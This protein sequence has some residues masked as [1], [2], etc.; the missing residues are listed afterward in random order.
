MPPLKAA[1]EAAQAEVEELK[2]VHSTVDRE[3]SAINSKI[4]RLEEKRTTWEARKTQLETQIRGENEKLEQEKTDLAGMLSQAKTVMERPELEH[5]AKYYERQ[6]T[7]LERA[8]AQEQTGRRD[9][10]VVAKELAAAQGHYA[11]TKETL[12]TLHTLSQQLQK[13][14]R[15]RVRMWYTIRQK[16]QIYCNYVFANLLSRRGFTGRLAFNTKDTGKEELAININMLASGR[17]TSDMRTLSGGEKSFSTVSLLLSMWAGMESPVRAMDEFDVY[18]DSVNRNVSLRLVLEQC[19][20]L[21]GQ[22]IFCTPIDLNAFINAS[23]VKVFRLQ[24]PVRGG[25]RQ[26]A[27]HEVPDTQP[28]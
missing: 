24:T 5:E 7:L 28:V 18:M 11:R 15:V 19:R 14:L 20:A 13:A 3:I 16:L 27:L 1:H 2:E 10:Q 12:G 8:V 21:G 23:D 9:D 4:Q 25:G 6:I 26:Q 17:D 22:Y